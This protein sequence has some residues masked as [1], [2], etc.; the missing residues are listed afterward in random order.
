MSADNSRFVSV[1]ADKTFFLWDVGGNRVVR[2]F[3]GHTSAINSVALN[4]VCQQRAQAEVEIVDVMV[5][6]GRRWPV[7]L[8]GGQMGEVAKVV[9]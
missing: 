2:K 8:W 4:E 9:S 7:C 3:W 5:L 1:G 6:Y